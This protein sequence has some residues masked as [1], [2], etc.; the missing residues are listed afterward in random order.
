LSIGAATY[1]VKIDKKHTDGY[2]KA[3]MVFTD[4]WSASGI[5]E[6][7]GT[8]Y[9][10]SGWSKEGINEETGTLYD[11]NGYDKDGYDSNGY[12]EWLTGSDY[13]IYY[14]SG[15]NGDYRNVKMGYYYKVD[16]QDG[17]KVV[18][19]HFQYTDDSKSISVGYYVYRPATPLRYK[20]N[21]IVEQA[22]GQKYEIKVGTW[23]KTITADTTGRYVEHMHEAKVRKVK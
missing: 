22:D 23:K 20:S 11:S 15:G 16:R 2:I 19:E 5:N 18:T 4:G 17:N 12:G 6:E 7:T 21:V 8:L 9:D 10:S 3:P 1:K 13:E 14:Y